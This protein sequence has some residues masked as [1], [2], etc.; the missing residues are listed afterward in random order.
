MHT[1]AQS[2][3]HAQLTLTCTYMF[4]GTCM[5]PLLTD[6]LLSYTLPN[7]HVAHVSVCTLVHITCSSQH[8][9]TLHTHAHRRTHRERN[10]S[11][12]PLAAAASSFNNLENAVG[13]AQNEQTTGYHGKVR[14]TPGDSEEGVSTAF[15]HWLPRTR[16]PQVLQH[17]EF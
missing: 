9:G 12:K 3:M 16:R 14:E 5:H 4:T 2:D 8:G 11:G 17:I 15:G 10:A 13:V 7:T 6:T 1:H